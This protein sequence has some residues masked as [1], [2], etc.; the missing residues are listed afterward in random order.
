MAIPTPGQDASPLPGTT[1]SDSERQ[2]PSYRDPEF[3]NT[4]HRL[5]AFSLARSTAPAYSWRSPKPV[6]FAQQHPLPEDTQFPPEWTN[7]VRTAIPVNETW[8]KTPNNPFIRREGDEAVTAS[9]T[10]TNSDF[11]QPYP[12]WPQHSD[13][14]PS[15]HSNRRVHN[16][17]NH[18]AYLPKP[19]IDHKEH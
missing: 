17:R 19:Q 7:D 14:I 1:T 11:H 5:Y 2:P 13:I 10:A 3:I 12:A 18:P 4:G 16:G 6:P 9:Q 15:P 8:L